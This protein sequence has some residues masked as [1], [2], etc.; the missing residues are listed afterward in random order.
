MA[1]IYM[2]NFMQSDPQYSTPDYMPIKNDYQF[3]PLMAYAVGKKEE[4][5]SKY[6]S[7]NNLKE[8]LNVNAYYVQWNYQL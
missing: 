6:L 8:Y 7:I 5:I 3:Y 1:E 4:G 2:D